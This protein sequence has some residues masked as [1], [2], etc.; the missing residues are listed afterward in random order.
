MDKWLKRSKDNT[1]AENV[2]GKVELKLMPSSNSTV[3]RILM[4]KAQ[5]NLIKRENITKVLFSMGLRTSQKTTTA[6]SVFN[7]QSNFGE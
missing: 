2:K 5:V 1:D 6:S 7:M 3:Q 4:A